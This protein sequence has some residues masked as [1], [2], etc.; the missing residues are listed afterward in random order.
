[1]AER[2]SDTELQ[3]DFER[4]AG[5]VGGQPTRDEYDEYGKWS[6]STIYDRG[7]T[8]EELAEEVGVETKRVTREELAEDVKRVADKLGEAPTQKQ[9]NEHGN[10]SANTIRAHTGSFAD[11]LIEL[12]LKPKRG[13]TD[14]H[15]IEDIRRVATIVDGV[16]TQSEYEQYGNHGT[17]T[18]R[19]RF[20]GWDDARRQAGLDPEAATGVT[21]QELREDFERVV[22]KL[23]H[24][25][26]APDYEEHGEYASSTVRNYLGPIP[27]LLTE[28]GITPKGTVTA[29][30]LIEDIQ[31]V[32][33]NVG[34]A[35]TCDQYDQHG[36]YS[37]TPV[38]NT[39]SSYAE[40]V[41]EA[42]HTPVI[43]QTVTREELR[44]DILRV[45]EIVGGTPTQQEY[46][47][48]GKHSP[49]TVAYH[50]GTWTDFII[51]IGLVPTRNI[52]R[53]QVIEDIE[54]VGELVNERGPTMQQYRQYGNFSTWIVFD[55]F[56]SWGDGLRAAGY[57]PNEKPT[58]EELLVTL[59]EASS[60]GIAPTSNRV[61]YSIKTYA[62]AF[63]SWWSANVLAGLTPRD[64]RPLSPESIHR[65][66]EVTIDLQPPEE[67]VIGL[68][69]QFTGLG[70]DLIPEFSEDWVADRDDKHIVK[71]P[72][73]LIETKKT[74][75]FRLPETWNN[76][77]LSERRKTHLPELLD[78]YWDHYNEAHPESA[79]YVIDLLYRI[80]KEAQLG[81]GREVMSHR[82][83]G[84]VPQIR[85]G[86]LR[87][88]RAIN[89]AR[90]GIPAESIQRQLGSEYVDTY[91]GPQQA[92][93]WLYA[94]EGYEHPD[95]EPPDAVLN[96]VS[97]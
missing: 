13:L 7:W 81:D 38:Y 62:R 8:F 80:G 66:H 65:V 57:L 75:I 87:I 77:Y 43:E 95:Y 74:W 63:G 12:D 14:E 32:A 11:F 22:D 41:R 29:E 40:A 28:M 94:H 64:R 35:P 6:S 70:G 15:L 59:R 90:Q 4:V 23:D 31:R 86:D 25:P 55:R 20:G 89:L 69:A 83:V 49:S 68:L 34:G 26:S 88:T 84:D 2:E 72:K 96:S 54:R 10:W 82:G 33:E 73:E 91:I 67:A 5:I 42:G 61:E 30:Q 44:D 50:H 47:E 36:E 93:A 3:D 58:D 48:H 56:G 27:D 37:L 21:E 1:M 16:P 18:M 17:T 45:A 52:P 24:P 92:F 85:G 79:S 46:T 78:W 19:R 39:F 71:V 51:D 53:D 9:Y 97:C 60:D 76:P